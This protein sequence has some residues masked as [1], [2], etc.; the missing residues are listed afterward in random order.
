[1]LCSEKLQILTSTEEN[2]ERKKVFKVTVCGKECVSSPRL[3]R[4][5]T[6]KLNTTQI[7]VT[8]TCI[9]QKI[10]ERFIF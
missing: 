7:C 5:T 10:P 4:H 9:C 3:K 2:N 1:M 8:R 6:L